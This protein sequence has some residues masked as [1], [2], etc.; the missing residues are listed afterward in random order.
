MAD[1][2]VYWKV[3]WE[4]RKQPDAF[5]PDWYTRYKY[6]PNQVDIGDNLWVVVWGGE[7]HPDK[8]RLIQ[9][10]SVKDVVFNNGEFHAKGD[11]KNSQTFDVKNQSDLT[12]ILRKLNFASG[13]R[14]TARG[15]LI[16]RSIQR[17]R[18]LSDSDVILLEQ[19]AKT[20]KT[21]SV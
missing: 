5:I 19:Y 4:Q 9:R 6:F 16:G 11:V 7:D 18:P 1:C 12:P 21:I 15:K 17:S 14:I 13:K 3:Y 2:L 8:W 20:L 10:I